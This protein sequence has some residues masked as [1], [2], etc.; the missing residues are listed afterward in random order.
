MRK[1]M[2]AAALGVALATMPPALAEEAKKADDSAMNAYGEATRAMTDSMMRMMGQMFKMWSEMS[3]PMWSSAAQMF[4][5]YGA[6]CGT[7]HTQLNNI[8]EQLGSSYD[9]N[10]HKKLSDAD[11]KKAAEAYK[12]QKKK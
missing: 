6:W 8:Y 10:V 7:C 11:L 9:P 1:V 5:D 4:G 3:R 12:A 2:L